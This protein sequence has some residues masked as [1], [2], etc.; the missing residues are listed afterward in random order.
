MPTDIT[1]KLKMNKLILIAFAVSILRAGNAQET[2]IENKLILGG[3]INFITQKNL[4]PLSSLSINFGTGGIYSNSTNDTKN[5]SLALT[6]YFG[7]EIN[8]NLIAGLRLNYRI[9]RYKAE[10]IYL[11]G[12]SNPIELVR[13]SNQFGIG[14]FTR[15]II[16]PNNKLCFFIQPYIEYNLLNEEEIQNSNVTQK[17]IVNYFELG[18]GLGISYNINNKLRATLTTG[19]LNYVNGKW[20][21]KDTDTKKY[22]SSLETNL[23]LTTIFFGLEIKI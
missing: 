17:E 2:E 21:I 11:F 14:I 15:H 6:A 23:N 9:G 7:K 8:P 20:E 10:D 22:F 13:N 4:Y 1:K 18:A 12:Q 16:N 19:G 5:T 3:S